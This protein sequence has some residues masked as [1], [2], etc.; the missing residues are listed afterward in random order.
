MRVMPLKGILSCEDSFCSNKDISFWD[1]NDLPSVSR[2][3]KNLSKMVNMNGAQKSFN[4]SLL[5][6]F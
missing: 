3:E 2:T 5:L 4:L 1:R 6:G